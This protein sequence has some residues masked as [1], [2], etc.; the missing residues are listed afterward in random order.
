MLTHTYCV[1]R[2]P[3]PVEVIIFTLPDFCVCERDALKRV[4]SRNQINL[5]LSRMEKDGVNKSERWHKM[6]N[7]VLFPFMLWC[8]PHSHLFFIQ[9]K[10]T[11]WEEAL[12][13][14]EL[15]RN[16]RIQEDFSRIWKHILFFLFCFWCTSSPFLFF[17][18]C[19]EAWITSGGSVVQE[20]SPDGNTTNQRG[21]ETLFWGEGL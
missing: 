6:V 12:R 10:I 17:I 20:K 15:G 14:V 9:M 16:G 5:S 19:Q 3:S 21:S 13:P 8:A 11:T 2:K 18:E 4:R 7:N 1:C